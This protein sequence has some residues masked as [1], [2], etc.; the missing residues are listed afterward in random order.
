[1]LRVL[2]YH[3]GRQVL[4]YDSSGPG[5]SKH[6]AAELYRSMTGTDILHVPYESSS[7]ARNDLTG[8]HVR[9]MFDDTPSVAPNVLAGQLRA[10]GTTGPRALSSSPRR[11]DPRGSRSA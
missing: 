5:S 9:M 8:G 10:L 4:T 3:R 11:A 7:G 2:A 6:M 1:M